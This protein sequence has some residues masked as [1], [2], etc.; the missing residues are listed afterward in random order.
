[1]GLTKPEE[2]LVPTSPE[3]EIRGSVG[4][5]AFNNCIVFEGHEHFQD[6]ETVC[7]EGRIAVQVHNKDAERT[8]KGPPVILD[9]GQSTTVKAGEWHTVYPLSRHWR[10]E[11]RFPFKDRAGNTVETY[12]SDV[13]PR[14]FL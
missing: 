10:Y 12:S 3:I 6:H 1:M 4:V 11:C 5:R 13:D 2:S 7:V 14:S 9:P 8:P